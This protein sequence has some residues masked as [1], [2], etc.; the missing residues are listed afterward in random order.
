MKRVDD[1]TQGKIL[2]P[3]IRF[4]LPVLLA[5]FLQTM[6]GAVDLLVVGQFGTSA[7][8]AAV[9]TGS[10][11]MQTVTSI[12]VGLAMSTTVLLGRR[13]GENKLNEAGDVIG[14][15][16][17]LFG[18]VGLIVTAAVFL[19]ALP[20]SQL[21]RAPEEALSKTAD[22]VRVCGLGSLFIVAY[23]ILG[24]I[25]RGLGNSRMPLITVAIATVV[26]IGGDLLLVGVFG[27][28]T[29]GAAIA[30]VAAQAVSV[31]LSIVIIRRDGLPFVFGRKN[32]RF[33]AGLI[34]E[35]L[36][37]GIPVALQDALVSISF[38]VI[39]A[40]VNSLGVVI[41]A[42]V[43]VAGK[44]INFIML[45]PSAYMQSMSAFVA[46][47]IG[48][49]K[50]K[51]ARKALW[52]GIATSLGVGVLMAYLSFFHGDLLAGIFSRDP[53]AV[54]AAAEYL[55]AYAIDCLLVS[56]LFCFTGY[57]NGCGQT[58]FVMMQGTLG[59][60][61]V[62]VPLSYY[63]SKLVPVSLFAIGLATPASTLLQ[64][65]LCMAYFFVQRRRQLRLENAGGC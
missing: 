23:N 55:R 28:A 60:F 19:T 59:A 52:C 45:V 33:R 9:S 12:I 16:I 26:N 54:A 63:M 10:H 36:R 42:G 62:R 22:Y 58:A 35:M 18:A 30:T 57:F 34:R 64:I 2:G 13:I 31:V 8:V 25:F 21:L 24:S 53:E 20:I 40:I 47:N 17:C 50:Y 46:Q 41:S 43:G 29:L 38:L 61:G 39:N 49:G 6:Y 11:V 3:L 1:F 65:T 51:R 7:D 37:I 32:I 48:A 4:A 27:L 15:S 14:T 44:L 5:I 56:F